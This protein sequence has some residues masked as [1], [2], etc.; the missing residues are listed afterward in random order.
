MFYFGFLY[1]NYLSRLCFELLLSFCC[2]N[3]KLA[4]DG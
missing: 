4:S 1:N 3:H 2:S